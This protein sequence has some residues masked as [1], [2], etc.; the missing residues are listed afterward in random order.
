MHASVQCSDGALVT[1]TF[2]SHAASTLLA[3]CSSAGAHRH[4]VHHYLL[5]QRVRTKSLFALVTQTSHRHMPVWPG[6]AVMAAL[7]A[8]SSATNASASAI[9]WS[10]VVKSSNGT[11][12]SSQLKEMGP[13]VWSTARP[14]PAT[15]AGVTTNKLQRFC[16]ASVERLKRSHMHPSSPLRIRLTHVHAHTRV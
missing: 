3:F 7:A 4:A 12:E 16:H 15:A 9:A 10:S 14:L 13:L 2:W 8:L 6:H 1:G 5:A 11:V